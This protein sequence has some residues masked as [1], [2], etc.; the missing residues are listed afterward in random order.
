M[1]CL[2]RV[3]KGLIWSL[4]LP[5]FL[6]TP[7]SAQKP[8]S[9]PTPT[10]L[11]VVTPQCITGCGGTSYSFVLAPT[12]DS[13][14]VGYNS[15]DTAIFTVTNTG[16]N[17]DTY[18]FTCSS[19]G[20]VSCSSVTP[21]SATLDGGGFPN[22]P[23]TEPCETCWESDAGSSV[24]IT[25]IY[26]VGTTTGRV[27]LTVQGTDNRNTG[28]YAISFLPAG[29]YVT[30]DGSY[31]AQLAN[32]GPF[33]APFTI[34]NYTL[35]T[36][37]FTV[38]CAGTRGVTCTGTSLTQA[39]LSSGAA[40][41]VNAT[42]NAGAP[43]TGVL[44][45]QAIGR[46][47][48]S[49]SGWYN[50]PIVAAGVAVT[51]D[52][53]TTAPR[54]ANTGSFT[55]TFTVKNTGGAFQTYTLTC[56]GS[57]NVTCSSSS[58]SGS[59]GVAANASA[60]VIA[61]YSVGAAG[62]GSLTLTAA[63]SGA[64]DGGTYHVRVV[65][66]TQQ[67]PVVALDSV[68]PGP[69]VPRELCMAIA[70][71]QGAASECGDLRI[72][73]ALPTT[74]SMNKARTPTLLYNSAFA[75]P[76]P[77]VAAQ[78]TLPTTVI[79]DSIEAVLT[80]NG[81]VR[82]TTRWG[83]A[84]WGAGSTRQIVVTYDGASDAT[85][86]YPYTLEVATI[87]GATRLAADK[88]GSLAIV[89][90]Q[91]SPFG[92]GW[93]LAGLEQL[94]LGTMVWVD[95]DGSVRQYTQVPGTTDQWTAPSVTHPDTIK[96]VVSGST[97]YVRYLGGGVEVWFNTQGQHVYTYNRQRHQTT[98]TYDPAKGVPTTITLP[99][100]TEG[101]AY[102]LNYSS[103]SPYHL[104]TV[105]APPIGTQVRK[106]S[107]VWGTG[108]FIS[109]IVDPDGRSV[110]F[111]PVTGVP[112]IV[113]TTT[114]RRGTQLT[115]SYD[116]VGGHTIT[117]SSLNMGSGQNPI[118]LIITP[119]QIQGL[120]K[121]S[122]DPATTFTRVDGPRTDV[123]D[124]TTV[125]QDRWGQPQVIHDALGSA[126]EVSRGDT[127]WPG[128]VTE[129]V[130]PNGWRVAAT[131]DPRGNIAS[132]A[133]SGFSGNPTTTYVWDQHWD[134]PT[135][136][137]RP[138]GDSTVMSYDSAT[139]NRLWQQDGRGSTTRVIFGYN[140][141]NQLTSI[142]PPGTPAALVTYDP[143]RGN[144]STS[145]TS[146]G[147]D[148]KYNTDTIGRVTEVDTRL[149]T[150]IG[151]PTP[152]YQ[153]TITRFDVLDRDTSQ[154]Q[155][156]PVM[157][158]AAAESIHVAAFF[159][160][161]GQRDSLKRWS[162]P[163]PA[164]I[165]VIR[166]RWS[167]DLA[168]RRVAEFAPDDSIGRSR[169][170]SMSYD[171]AGNVVRMKGRVGPAITMTYDALNR[172]LQRAMPVVNG[173]GWT[174]N[175]TLLHTDPNHNVY[176]GL[177]IP[178]QTDTFTYDVMGRVLTANNLDARVRRSYY[179]NGLLDTDSSWIQTLNRD[180]WTKHVYGL[181]NQYDRD[182][183]RIAIEI[184]QQLGAPGLAGVM[185]FGYEPELGTLQTVWDL[186]DSSYTFTFDAL[187]QLTALTYPSQYRES[188][189]YDPD[190]RLSTDSIRNLGSIQVPRLPANIIRA[191]GYQYDAQGRMLR[192]GDPTGFADTLVTAYSGL[193][194][195]TVSTLSEHPSVYYPGYDSVLPSRFT[196]TDSNYAD[197][198]ANR[199]SGS[200]HT[201]TWVNGVFYGSTGA[202]HIT[203]YQAGTGRMTLDVLSNGQTSYTYDSAGNTVFSSNQG[204]AGPGGSGPAEERAMWYAADNTLRGVDW[205]WVG[206][207]QQFTSVERFAQDQ[208]RYDALGRRVWMW[209]E[210][211]GNNTD[212][213][214]WWQLAETYASLVRRTIWDGNQEIAE[215]QMPGDG[216]SLRLSFFEND[217]AP[218]HLP[219]QGTHLINVDMN[220]YYGRAFYTPGR[221]VDEPVAVTRVNYEYQHDDFNHV[222]PDTVL[223]PITIVPFWN[224]NGDAPLGV[225][226][227]GT[228]DLCNP[229]QTA[230]GNC[231]NVDWS[232]YWSPFDRLNPADVRDNWNGTL[233]E[234]K[235]DKS[236]LE[237]DRNRYYD[238]ATGR[239]TQEDPQGLAGGLN[240]YGFAS[241]DP[242]NLGDPFGLC[243]PWPECVFQHVANDGVAH[244]GFYG[245][246]LLNVGAFGNALSEVIRFNEWGNS[247][248]HG[249]LNGASK[250]LTG[251]V[252]MFIA[253]EKAE[254][255]EVGA[256]FDNI[257]TELKTSNHFQ[258]AR[259]E[260][261]G[262]LITGFDHGRELEDFANGL[263]N[264]TVR[265]KKLLG[266][267][268]AAVRAEAQRL[269]SKISK[270]RDAI[271]EVLD[272]Q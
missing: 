270:L 219:E 251:T 80:V 123:A 189:T 107:L 13:I 43:G 172:L 147:F 66:S 214:T 199:F 179:P 243:D 68:N 136:I 108:A 65:T 19:T 83:G 3:V 50:V 272:D 209:T 99:T 244:G 161:N 30:P 112:E 241:G 120:G 247:L 262:R 31:S 176:P 1:S 118:V 178:A 57:S 258:A 103:S 268:D 17:T 164:H 54:A 89:N 78:V 122:V 44:T 113:G 72:V 208:Y 210:K 18:F 150:I 48:G 148:T 104:L 232:F 266:S 170:D 10:P 111:T 207:P 156:G 126:T 212:A 71:G 238:P 114:D 168:G 131:Y 87:Y 90:R 217:I 192:S 260:R 12:S 28:Y 227:T 101:L 40:S 77:L 59:I 95:G 5:L 35:A 11:P 267:N 8:K 23:F 63:A 34:K 269:L 2:R 221:G 38:L 154:I 256:Q 41:T 246:V 125:W 250:E 142:T 155:G 151:N 167:Y 109:Q 264:S 175:I 194:K 248:K 139:G 249:D 93:W 187:G 116:T 140:A 165:G 15:T 24:N 206:T 14:Q 180:N 102:Q 124:T 119:Q 42:Y 223:P 36:D 45:L 182:G 94:N 110:Q 26:T 263:R 27:S 39:I 16:T 56:A 86:I 202:N 242:V 218:T 166:T 259:L 183:R 261:D 196:S 141:S 133:D 37:T 224:R 160:A 204:A 265:L 117:G 225:Y 237:F 230:P 239:F 253:P 7:A 97:Y 91:A 201:S 74:R 174:T 226:S 181:R 53:G 171:P 75:H 100:G 211:S 96:K 137:K 33:T 271:I 255:E 229:P 216:D 184:P 222:L 9:K 79:P 220:Q 252:V 60:P 22:K 198:L 55:D 185:R 245:D 163:D 85:G 254:L 153:S 98:F 46:H 21:S 236:G 200:T 70:L 121:Q 29:V 190:G 52:G 92:A 67:A 135:L 195:V 138:E 188:Y 197:A 32:A 128:L 81:T 84:Q 231:V 58:P 143:A 105:V 76:F 158:G 215:I 240:L 157:N 64:S 115:F 69:T 152:A 149:D 20:S 61:T 47:A 145:V 132:S 130:H 213:L 233:L 234:R 162:A 235:R 203:S 6:A 25:V 191:S 186:E 51:P 134:A 88:T 127:R 173:A 205:A 144:I 169:V 4:S 159:N 257:L 82:K 129:V 146:K 62:T 49:D 228:R 177:S 73:H 106:D 193:G